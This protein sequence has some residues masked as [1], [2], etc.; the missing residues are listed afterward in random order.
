[1]VRFINPTRPADPP[2]FVWCE[3]QEDGFRLVRR[4]PG[5]HLHAEQVATRS[6]L[7]N[8]T[9]RLQA[10]LTRSGWTPVATAGATAARRRTARSGHFH[11]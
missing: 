8:A 5:G 10:E 7:Y 4:E 1:M 2:L 9:V 3:P 6:A 11:R